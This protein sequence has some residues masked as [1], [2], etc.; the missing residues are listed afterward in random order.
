[1][2]E[3]S[4]P[5]DTELVKLLRHDPDKAMPRIFEKHY[6]EVCHHIYRIIPSKETCEDIA[7][8]IFLELWNKRRELDIRT[9]IG[10][11]LHKMA[12]SRALNFLR[13]NKKHLHDPEE[14]LSGHE[15]QQ[16]SP[17]QQLTDSEL[18]IVITR[19]IES[20]PS[21]CREVF[22]LSRFEGLSYQEIG[23]VLAIS[24]KTVENQISK[25]LLILR[26]AV[27]NYAADDRGKQ[28]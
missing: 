17:L 24:P 19:A 26:S 27:H 14:H 21:R 15:I 18:Q 2:E 7:Q 6:V 25:A 5:G 13:D 28:Q 10:A 11:Y 23:R 12:L 22:V 9:S 8:S 4:N 16:S 3:H 1:L 20:L